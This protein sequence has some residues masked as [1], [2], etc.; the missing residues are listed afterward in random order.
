MSNK[1]PRRKLAI[2]L[3][4]SGVVFISGLALGLIFQDTIK[5][6]ASNLMANDK[7]KDTP[8]F[9]FDSASL[10]DWATSGNSWVN[11]DEF[12]DDGSG[13]KDELPVSSINVQQ[14]DKGSNCSQLISKCSLWDDN[15][16]HCQKLVQQTSAAPCFVMAFY[17]DTVIDSATAADQYISKQK[18][19]GSMVIT[20][21]NTKTLSMDTPE[22]NKQYS[23]DYYDY[24]NKSDSQTKRGNAIGYLALTNGHVEVRSICTASDQ[25]DQTLPALSAIKLEK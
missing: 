14:C 3:I 19:F 6:T 5:T 9:I 12:T 25:L 10:P 4:I 13:N 21:V 11:P 24:E 2:I 20:K 7:N 8:K 23:L 22:G 15:N 16:E 17:K 1:Q 18:A